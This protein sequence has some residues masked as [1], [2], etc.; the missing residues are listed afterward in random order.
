MVEASGAKERLTKVLASRGVASRREAERMVAEGR[1]MVDGKVVDR[2]IPV[3]PSSQVIKV[4]G[5]RLPEEPHSVYMLMYKPRGTITGRNDPK[6]RPS[7]FDLLEDLPVRVEP[8]GRLDLNTEG[9]LLLTNDG[10]LAH[11]LLHPSHEVPK[12]YH[13]KV[14]RTPSDSKLELVRKGKVYLE[15]GRVSP[16]KVRRLEA[17]EGSGNSW[18]EITITEGRNRLVRRLFQQLGHPVSKLRRESFATLSIRGMER[19]QVRLLTAD[20]VRRLRDLAAGVTPTRAGSAARKGKGFAKAK[21]KGRAALRK[22]QAARKAARREAREA[23]G[24]QGS[25]K[26]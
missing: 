8:V 15:D 1:V 5:R 13:V 14:W 26:G 9:A 7:V 23:E 21:P 16:A 4:D 3:D 11:R 22:V 19:G 24:P 6:G 17:S 20:E 25:G 18:I 12:R 10:D 2:V